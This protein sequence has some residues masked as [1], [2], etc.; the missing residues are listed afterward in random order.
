MLRLAYRLAS[1]AIMGLLAACS[2]PPAPA[3]V[4]APSQVSSTT[5]AAATSTPTPATPAPTAQL[6]ATP[7]TTP[8]AVMPG[9]PWLVYQYWD[10]EAHLRLIRPDGA[11]MHLLLPDESREQW[12]PDWSP[13]GARIAFE[14]DGE[15]W[16]AAADGTDLRRLASCE[17]PCRDLNQPAWS[18]DG[19]SLVVQLDRYL[20]TGNDTNRVTGSA[21]AVVDL[22]AK[23]PKPRRLTDWTMFAA[24]PDWDPTKDLIVFSTCDLGGRDGG[25][26]ADSSPP[27]DLYTVRSDGTG[28]TQLTHN[29]NGTQLTRNDTASGPLSS[30]PT[31]SPDG[32]S[33]IFVQTVGT[34]WPGWT[35][36][37]INADGTGLAPAAGSDFLRG[38]HPRLR[39]LP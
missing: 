22:T 34:Q 1:L 14:M 35:M 27:S 6:T 37:T 32:R 9:E 2:T 16:V 24:Y 25:S 28:M 26:F 8:I 39:P 19:R 23:A 30:Q 38:T 15:I 5:T 4:A 11:D 21:V 20:D 33:I 12:H 36:A 29:P 18:P 10:Q 13:D 7:A 17:S 3:P 31:W